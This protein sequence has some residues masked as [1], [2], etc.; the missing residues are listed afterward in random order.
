MVHKPINTFD[1]ERPRRHYIPKIIYLYNRRKTLIALHKILL[2]G[3]TKDFEKIRK[4]I[5]PTLSLIVMV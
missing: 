1:D 4:A 2:I 3:Q 5:T